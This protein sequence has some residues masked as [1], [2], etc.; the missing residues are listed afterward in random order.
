MPI[1]N[2]TLHGG[3]KRMAEE[4][5]QTKWKAVAEKRCDETLILTG[6]RRSV[7][8]PRRR[9]RNNC[10]EKLVL[11]FSF[12]ELGMY[13]AL[14]VNNFLPIWK[15]GLIRRPFISVPPESTD[16]KRLLRITELVCLELNLAAA[17]TSTDPWLLLNRGRERNR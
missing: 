11:G 3:S 16:S 5:K 13:F 17:F 9:Y 12:C 15:S 7:V 14:Q 6:R 1:N 2:A 8:V 10:V 4:K